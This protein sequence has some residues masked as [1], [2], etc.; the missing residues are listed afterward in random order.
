MRLLG[1]RASTTDS[2]TKKMQ[3]SR[4]Q[5]SWTLWVM[6]F[7]KTPL[8]KSRVKVEEEVM[9]REERVD[10]DAERTRIMTTPISRSGR[11][12]ASIW[13]TMLSKT[14]LPPSGTV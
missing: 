2:A 10:I 7:M 5:R 4:I 11:E 13:G 9:T 14:G 3:S 12:E 1:L 6:S 8:R